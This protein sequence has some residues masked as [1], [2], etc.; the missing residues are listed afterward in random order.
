MPCPFP[1]NSLLLAAF[2]Y[3]AETM[4]VKGAEKGWEVV[5]TNWK[6]YQEYAAMSYFFLLPADPK[7]TAVYKKM[8]ILC[9]LIEIS[10]KQRNSS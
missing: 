5:Y 2:S 9:K 10:L 1:F 3:A 7:I 8:L 6:L 4:K